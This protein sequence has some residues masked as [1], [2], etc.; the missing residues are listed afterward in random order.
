[1]YTFSVLVA[2]NEARPSLSKKCCLG[3][4]P[5]NCMCGHLCCIHQHCGQNVAPRVFATPTMQPTSF[6]GWMEGSG[7]HFHML[8]FPLA[9]A[10]RLSG[11]RRA[12]SVCM[13][14]LCR[15]HAGHENFSDLLAAICWT[16]R[17]RFA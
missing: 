5:Q 2:E 8:A 14:G 7:L 10:P 17:R 3:A 13:Y 15:L 9:L 12:C 4:Q 16:S 1:M 6:T 11:N